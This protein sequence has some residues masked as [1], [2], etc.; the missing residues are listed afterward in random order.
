MGFVLNAPSLDV[1]SEV[2]LLVK[3]ESHKQH[4]TATVLAVQYYLLLVFINRFL[5]FCR[6]IS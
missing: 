1:P 6:K 2:T 4:N 3:S 5:F